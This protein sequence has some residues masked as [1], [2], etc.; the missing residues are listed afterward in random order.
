MAD[1]R[2]EVQELRDGLVL[3]HG[4]DVGAGDH[5][6]RN[7]GFAEFENVEQHQAFL[8]RQG[9]VVLRTHL[10]DCGFERFPQADAVGEPEVGRHALKPVWRCL[11]FPRFVPELCRHSFLLL[12]C[13]DQRAVASEAA[14]SR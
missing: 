7:F 3:L 11:R 1:A 10:L 9:L 2:K 14:S 8:L 13:C 4:D 6:L 12:P 5:H